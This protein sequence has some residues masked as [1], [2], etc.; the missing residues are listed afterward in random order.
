M[1]RV[2]AAAVLA[3][4][5][6]LPVMAQ[7][8]PIVLGFKGGVNLANLSMDPETDPSPDMYLGLAVGGLLG[9]EI[10]PGMTLDTDFLYIQKGAKWEGE[11]EGDEY[12]TT[13]KYSYVVI[14]PMLRFAVQNQGL[15]PYFMAGPEIGF[16]V[17]A[18]AKSEINGEDQDDEDLK[19]FTKSTD[20]GINFGAGLEFP[21]GNSAFFVE[22]RYAMG[23]TNILDDE[24]EDNKQEDSKQ[25]AKHRGIYLMG[26][27][28]F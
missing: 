8:N 27:V 6:A 22:G 18:T 19:D 25:E 24:D 3:F 10:S 13:E 2:V 15:R 4:L 7:T 26:G 23:L 1:K 16:L 9:F 12:K 14:N 21:S 11:D 17:D 28:R 20:F 5:F